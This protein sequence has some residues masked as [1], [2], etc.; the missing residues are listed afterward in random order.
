MDL[1]SEFRN[2]EKYLFP[3]LNCD[4]WERTMYYYLL[5]NTRLANLEQRLFS[6]DA[7]SS[8]TKMNSGKVRETIRSMDQKGSMKIVERNRNGHLIRVLFPSEIEGLIVDT[9][10]DKE[11]INI[12][13]LDFYKGRKYLSSLMERDSKRCIYCL[14]HV[15]PEK[16]VLDH[17]VP[18]ARAGDNSYRNI[19]VSCHDCN[20]RKGDSDPIEFIRSLYRND[21]L[22][23]SEFQERKEFI[24]KVRTGIVKPQ[25]AN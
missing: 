22:T 3:K 14:K 21:M 2:I 16:C 11:E 17:I 9:E 8:A 13:D 15:T 12:E 24:E 1:Q 5:I 10:T 7:L 19:A 20:S 18:L 6:V 23:E 25:M 4:P